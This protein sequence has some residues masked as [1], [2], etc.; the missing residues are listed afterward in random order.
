LATQP[1]TK[2]LPIRRT[3]IRG[4]VATAL[5]IV[6]AVVAEFLVVIYAMDLGVSDPT[7][8]K[9]NWPVT[10]V[11]SPLFNLV[12][13]ALI[14]TLVFTWVYLSRKFAVKGQELRKGKV[15]IPAKRGAG[16][17]KISS[18]ISRPFRN[19]LA[20]IRSV[21]PSV[22]SALAVIL[23][24]LLFVLVASLLAYPQLIYRAVSSA[25]QNNPSLLDF[26]LSVDKSVKGF[27]EAV[28]PIGWIGTSVNNALLAGAA[29]VGGAGEGL[30]SLLGPVAD[31]DNAGKY[32]V[33]QNAAAW[34]SVFLILFYGE[35]LRKGYRYRRK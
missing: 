7:L 24:F 2:R 8:L 1:V 11:I 10:I 23:L 21:N 12:P 17:K 34:I 33:F 18:R 22:K 31:L 5:F 14:V 29:G 27:A 26:V 9:T 28:S 15:Q 35:F 20:K 13:I 16:S 19:F 32:L 30:G 25:Y 3:A 4:A 6:V